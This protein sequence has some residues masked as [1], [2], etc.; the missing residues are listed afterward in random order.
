MDVTVIVATYGD[1]AYW[2]SLAERAMA[3]AGA[4]TT[5]RYHGESI[6]QAR[7]QAAE[8]A[9]SEWLCFLD[10]DDELAPGYLEAM[11]RATGDLRAPLV[12][13]VRKGRPGPAHIPRGTDNMADGNRL[14]IGTL[15]RRAMFC[16]VGGFRD[17]PFYEDFDLWQRCWLVGAVIEFVHDA[18]YCAH[19]RPDSRN[20][21]PSRDEK[22]VVHHAIRRANMPWLYDEAEAS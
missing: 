9:D 14:V 4:A 11:E 3:S 2:D 22:L 6:H 16:E 10:A 15:V 17:W 21:T 18:V 5:L 1:R 7:N 12:R 13:Y 8:Y 19:V 20:R